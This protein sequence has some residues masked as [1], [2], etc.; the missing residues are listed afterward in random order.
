MAAPALHRLV[1][2]GRGGVVV[3]RHRQAVL[4][5]TAGD[6]RPVLVRVARL[7]ASRRSIS[8]SSCASLSPYLPLV[9]LA[10]LVHADELSLARRVIHQR[11]EAHQRIV[12]ERLEVLHAPAPC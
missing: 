8:A 5:G 9:V 2:V 1:H 10:V 3:A 7:L 11:D 12:R 4:A 6:G